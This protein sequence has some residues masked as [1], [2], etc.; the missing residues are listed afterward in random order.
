MKPLLIVLA[1]FGCFLHGC[2]KCVESEPP[3]GYVQAKV[4]FHELATCGYT[5]TIP[6]EGRSFAPINLPDRHKI[7]TGVDYHSVFIKYRIL[8]GDTLFCNGVD[9]DSNLRH[10]YPKLEITDIL[11]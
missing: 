3:Q 10:K 2:K 9:I 1:G 8:P 11:E 6:A 7:W 5:L 4:Y